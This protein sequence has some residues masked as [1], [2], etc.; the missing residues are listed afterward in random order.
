MQS[1]G[2]KAAKDDYIDTSRYAPT[3]G[4]MGMKKGRGNPALA[5]V[6]PAWLAVRYSILK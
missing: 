5:Y 2:L 3:G 4:K 1:S 6:V